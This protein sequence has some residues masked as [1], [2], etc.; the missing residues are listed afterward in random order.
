MWNEG[1]RSSPPPGWKPSF[2]SQSG[3]GTNSSQW[4]IA[5][6]ALREFDY[7]DEDRRERECTRQEISCR[8]PFG[9]VIEVMD[10]VRKIVDGDRIKT[11][12]IE[13]LPAGTSKTF[14]R[15]S[16][17]VLVAGSPSTPPPITVAT[18]PAAQAS[19]V[20]ASVGSEICA[21]IRAGKGLSGGGEGGNTTA[22]AICRAE[23]LRHI[24][25]VYIGALNAYEVDGL[26][27]LLEEGYRAEQEASIREQIDEL[28]AAGTQLTWTEDQLPG[29]T[30]PT[31]MALLIT[32]EG[33]PSGAKHWQIGFI[34]VGEKDSG[35]WA[36]TFVIV[37][38]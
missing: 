22:F 31:S 20:A 3:R 2:L 26:L 25:D 14:T 28:K 12:T 11:V 33:G 29:R 18:A 5:L 35:D 9:F 34:E 36:I 27:P 24:V 17:P 6:E 7:Y 10:I 38:E 8:T 32:V 21:D 30:G 4:F 1:V 23:S 16:Q 37:K 19:P 15:E 13:K